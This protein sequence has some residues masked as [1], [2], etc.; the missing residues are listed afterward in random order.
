MKNFINVL[1]KKNTKNAD[2]RYVEF[3]G[4]ALRTC[5]MSGPNAEN[6]GGV[7]TFNAFRKP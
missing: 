1:N 5:G 2:A 4:A 3:K 7:L 6:S